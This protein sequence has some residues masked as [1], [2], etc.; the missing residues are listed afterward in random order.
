MEEEH[1]AFNETFFF[2]LSISPPGIFEFVMT[3][4]DNVQVFKIYRMD[5]DKERLIGQYSL[6]MS[7]QKIAH[8]LINP[9]TGQ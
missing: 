8:L 6:A 2:G 1:T 4:P 5:D 3:D 7:H 9:L